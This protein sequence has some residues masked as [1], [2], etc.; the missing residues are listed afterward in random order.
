[1]SAY[2]IWATTYG[3]CCTLAR[4]LNGQWI[5]VCD[6]RPEVYVDDGFGNLILYIAPEDQ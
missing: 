3:H 2:P 4:L 5:E 6:F 1:M